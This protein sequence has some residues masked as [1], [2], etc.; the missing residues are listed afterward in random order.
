MSSKTAS[1]GSHRLCGLL[2]IKD[3]SI[4]GRGNAGSVEITATDTITIDGET[5][6]GFSSGV[7]SGVGSRA[8]G[9]AGGVSITTGSLTLTNG[10]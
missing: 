2:K 1:P 3:A 6:R 8:E 5:S 4:S 10:G 9:N 7:T